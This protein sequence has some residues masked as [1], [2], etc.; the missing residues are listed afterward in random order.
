MAETMSLLALLEEDDP[1]DEQP[2]PSQMPSIEAVS[3]END[4]EEDG[5]D[6]DG[7]GDGD[8]QD[9]ED[10][11]DMLDELDEELDKD[12]P[13]E[14]EGEGLL[15]LQLNVSSIL[16]E[17]RFALTATRYASSKYYG[18]CILRLTC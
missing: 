5:A 4:A 3:V 16:G 7:D 2:V 8:G 14:D 11:D 13:E 6:A 15:P 10:D 12:D 1:D 9:D 17:Q 18:S